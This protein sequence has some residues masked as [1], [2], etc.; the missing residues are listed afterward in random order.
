MFRF[1]W[2]Y[3]IILAA[4]VIASAW[5]ILTQVRVSVT[6]C[7]QIIPGG[8]GISSCLGTAVDMSLWDYITNREYPEFSH[9]LD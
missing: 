7:G 4:L 2:W 3:S 9:V 1:R 5:L 8:P 6:L